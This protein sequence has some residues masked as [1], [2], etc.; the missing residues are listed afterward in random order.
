M[1]LRS[2]GFS[3]H[4]QRPFASSSRFC[5]NAWTHCCTTDVSS[6]PVL[7]LPSLL[8]YSGMDAAREDLKRASICWSESWHIRPASK[9]RP[10]SLIIGSFKPSCAAKLLRNDAWHCLGA[11]SVPTLF[12]TCL[13]DHPLRFILAPVLLVNKP[14]VPKV[15]PTSCTNMTDLSQVVVGGWVLSLTVTVWQTR[16]CWG[17]LLSLCCIN[18]ASNLSPSRS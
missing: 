1:A 11:P 17:G 15:A 4:S 5:L 13:P 2:D 3:F 9:R 14:P 10:S 7:K 8:W 16:R 6:T 18:A 12:Q